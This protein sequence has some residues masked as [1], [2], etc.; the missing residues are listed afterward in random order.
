MNKRGE[1]EAQVMFTTAELIIVALVFTAMIGTVTNANAQT[2]FERSYLAKDFSLLS[3]SIQAA[4]GTV[5]LEYTSD[6]LSLEEFELNF[7]EDKFYVKDE[8]EY[9]TTYPTIHNTQTSFKTTPLKSSVIRI[10][11]Q[12]SIFSIGEQFLPESTIPGCPN[13]PLKTTDPNWKTKPIY[14]FEQNTDLSANRVLANAANIKFIEADETPTNP[15]LLLSHNFKDT[16]ISTAYILYNSIHKDESRKLACNIL[17][18]LEGKKQLKLIT[19]SDLLNPN[20]IGVALET[21]QL[22]IGAYGNELK[23]VFEKY[24]E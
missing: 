10:S 16:Q 7:R 11:K 22:N 2:T 20:T 21:P 18:S 23:N 1:A 17:K 6:K 14:I 5:N 4:P 8:D 24:F 9:V 12:N 15:F 19:D 13:Q 3:Q